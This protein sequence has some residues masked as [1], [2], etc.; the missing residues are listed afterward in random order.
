MRSERGVALL[1]VLAALAIVGVAALALVELEAAGLRATGVARDRELELADA[2]RLMA[3][4]TL[5]TRNELD[6]RLG[7]RSVGRYLVNVQRAE[8][9][10]Y[11]IAIAGLTTVVYKPEARDAR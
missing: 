11:R 7:D 6:Q 3:A 2:D 4:Y 1:E 8:P 10:L 5:L 9:D